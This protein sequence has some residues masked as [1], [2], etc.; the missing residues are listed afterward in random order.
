MIKLFANF[1]N[2]LYEK[3]LLRKRRKWVKGQRREIETCSS[4]SNMVNRKG[5]GGG[6]E[7]CCAM[8]SCA[9]L[10]LTPFCV[11]IIITDH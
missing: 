1:L 2:S 5:D 7:L 6:E 11:S 3:I 4:S 8:W 10:W 9:K